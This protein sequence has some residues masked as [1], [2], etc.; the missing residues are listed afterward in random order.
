[1]AT[2]TDFAM[3]RAAEIF[4]KSGKTL[5]DLGILMGYTSEIARRA[6]WQFLRKTGDPRLSMLRKFAKAMRVPI[7][8]LVREN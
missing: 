4:E 8:K 2:N 1:M 3:K 6:A 5:E 7:E